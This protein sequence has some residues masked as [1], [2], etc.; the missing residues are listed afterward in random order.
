MTSPDIVGAEQCV[1]RN[2]PRT[3]LARVGLYAVRFKLPEDVDLNIPNR[4]LANQAGN[5][6]PT[7]HDPYY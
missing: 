5:N 6:F 7:H 4:D 2:P 1:R 3:V